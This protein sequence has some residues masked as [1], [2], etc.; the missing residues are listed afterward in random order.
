MNYDERILSL[1]KRF[2][3]SEEIHNEIIRRLNEKDISEALMRQQL[4]TLV[5]TTSRIENK[6]DEQQQKPAKRQEVVITTIITAIISFLT[7]GLLSIF[8]K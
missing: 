7:G 8:K 2:E 6:I 4:D 5:Q 1:E 3:H